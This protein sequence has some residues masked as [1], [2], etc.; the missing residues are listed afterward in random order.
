MGHKHDGLEV[1]RLPAARQRMV[2]SKVTRVYLSLSTILPMNR[3]IH[4]KL[5]VMEKGPHHTLYHHYF[6]FNKTVFGKKK[7]V[8]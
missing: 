1:E 7:M 2:V 3:I 6:T 4:L 5:T 8:Q